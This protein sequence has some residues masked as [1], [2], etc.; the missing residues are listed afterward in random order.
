MWNGII[1]GNNAPPSRKNRHIRELERDPLWDITYADRND[2]YLQSEPINGHIPD[3]VARSTFGETVVGE[4]E[5]CG[6]NSQHT[7]SQHESFS[8]YADQRGPMVDFE[9]NEYGSCETDHDTGLDLG[10]DTPDPDLDFGFGSDADRKKDNRGG[11][12]L[13]FF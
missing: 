4:T 2:D 6:D 7:R 10:F 8:N 1:Q 11:G 9:L 5:R 12:L 13:D 3:Y